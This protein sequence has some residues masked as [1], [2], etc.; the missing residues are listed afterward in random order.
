MKAQIGIVSLACCTLLCLAV[1]PCSATG[2]NLSSQTN[3]AGAAPAQGEDAAAQQTGMRGA[4]PVA[5]TKSL[6]SK[7]LKAGDQFVCEVAGT[8]R[9]AN[10]MLIPAG[11]RVT[12]HVTQATAR[13]RGDSD[14]SLAVVFDKMEMSKG[15]ELAMT[16]TL[17]AVAPAVGELGPNNDTHQLDEAPA[18]SGA[19]PMNTVGMSSALP[20]NRAHSVLNSESQGVVGIRDLQMSKDSILTSNGKQVKLDSGTQLMIRAVIQISAP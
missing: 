15:K 7:K 14:S 16:G 11:T 2:K 18:G 12:G 9:S 13:A 20:P 4:F 3:A 8:I 5:L 17:Q 10:G 1:Q 19:P 6:E